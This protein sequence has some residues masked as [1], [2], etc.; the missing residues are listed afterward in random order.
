[1]RQSPKPCNGWQGE[2]LPTSFPG[3]ISMYRYVPLVH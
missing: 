1:M 2:D 3:E